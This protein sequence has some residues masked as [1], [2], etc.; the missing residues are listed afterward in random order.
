MVNTVQND[1][2]H[3]SRKRYRITVTP[4]ENNGRP[5]DDRCTIE[6]EQ[7]SRADWM[8]LLEELHLR[9]DLSSD[10]CAALTVGSQLL[11][12]LAA[13]PR[14][15]PSDTLDALRPKL[16]LLL[17]RLQRVQPATGA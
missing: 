5:C 17:E 6:F 4:I 13:R 8:R 3:M 9:R 15:Q 16:Q 10:E 2:A 12:D 11:E 7:R 1:A 14:V